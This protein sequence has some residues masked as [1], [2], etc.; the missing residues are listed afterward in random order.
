M[1]DLPSRFKQVRLENKLTQR[2]VAEMIGISEQSYQRYEYGKVVP[3]AL[4]LI[5]LADALGVSLDY[6][7][8]RTDTP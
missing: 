5:S 6:L 2:Q 4:V 8:G 1:Y 3:S 7:V